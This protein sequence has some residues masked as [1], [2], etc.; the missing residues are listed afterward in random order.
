MKYIIT[1]YITINIMFKHWALSTSCKIKSRRTHRCIRVLRY[2][3]FIRGGVRLKYGIRVLLTLP[4]II[5]KMPFQPTVISLWSSL[6][7]AV[8]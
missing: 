5:I 6:W 2:G 1:S 7:F 3:A 8:L 4:V